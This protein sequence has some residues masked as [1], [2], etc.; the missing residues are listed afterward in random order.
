MTTD[1]NQSPRAGDGNAKAV[2]A[3]HLF[4]LIDEFL[5]PHGWAAQK[6][7]RD[8]VELVKAVL[9]AAPAAAPD[10]PLTDALLKEAAENW[11]EYGDGPGA[12]VSRRKAAL[13]AYKAGARFA[14]QRHGIQAP[15]TVDGRQP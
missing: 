9:A 11:H 2:E 3:A 6:L 4:R 15:A 8:Y 14:E 7:L 5:K 12:E 13:M 1:N 10:V